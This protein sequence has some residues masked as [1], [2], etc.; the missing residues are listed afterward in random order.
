VIFSSSSFPSRAP[1]RMGA[2]TDVVGSRCRRERIGR[3]TNRCGDDGIGAAGQAMQSQR[4]G[5]LLARSWCL[6]GIER[7]GDAMRGDCEPAAPASKTHLFDDGLR[8]GLTHGCGRWVGSCATVRFEG[9]GCEVAVGGRR[10]RRRR[11]W[12][13]GLV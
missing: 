12:R 7:R 5:E 2:A 3:Q 6:R 13:K 8:E 10:R 1:N 11:V 4:G 9:A